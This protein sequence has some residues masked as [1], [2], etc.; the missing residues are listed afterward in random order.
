VGGRQAGGREGRWRAQQIGGSSGQG[1]AALGRV[2]SH[3]SGHARGAGRR[4]DGS[5]C[6][7]PEHH[8]SNGHCGQ[9]GHEPPGH[10]PARGLVLERAA[11]LEG[12]CYCKQGKDKPGTAH[13]MAQ[14][15]A[16]A[17]GARGV[18]HGLCLRIESSQRCNSQEMG[19]G[20][21]RDA[22]VG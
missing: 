20:V 2:H 18:G 6:A 16:G 14:V 9:P 5:S 4:A 21:A 12:E 11:Q 13:A 8:Q 17:A 1:Q 7:A 3:Q 19:R 22:R 15:D 10:V